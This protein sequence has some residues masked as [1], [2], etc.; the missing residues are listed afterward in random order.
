MQKHFFLIGEILKPQGINGE[1][2][3][4]TYTEDLENLCNVEALYIKK[5]DDFIKIEVEY[6][7]LQ[8][9]D[10]IFKFVNIDDRNTA[11]T[12]R[13]TLLYINREDASPLAD[14]EYYINDIIGFNIEDNHGNFI[15]KLKEVLNHGASDI[16]VL[17]NENTEILM[18][19]LKKLLLNTDLEKG[20]IIVNAEVLAEVAVY[21]N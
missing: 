13:G 19:A 12:L 3:L 17:K 18:P 10:A 21:N 2:K 6:A 4:K 9:G 8:V 15:G 5:N 14:G 11:E 20:I 7:R 16:Y 1:V